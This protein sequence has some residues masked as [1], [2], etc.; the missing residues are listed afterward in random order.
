M[1]SA[2]VALILG[3]GANIG[4]G[5]ARALTAKGYKVALASRTEPEKDA[6]SHQLHVKGDFAN[7]ESI[8]DIFS[9]VEAQL[10]LPHVV[11]YNGI[12][13]FLHFSFF[14]P[15]PHHLRLRGKHG[16]PFVT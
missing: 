6:A 14:T 2:P 4:L 5:V 11:V 10:G 15:S 9:K 12:F 13:S 1:S 8:L 16:P 3:A 7:P